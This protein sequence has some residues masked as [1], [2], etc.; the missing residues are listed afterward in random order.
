MFATQ[1]FYLNFLKNSIEIYEYRISFIHGK[2]VVI[3]DNW[4][5]VGSPNIDHFSLLLAHEANVVVQESAFATQLKTEIML[6]IHDSAHRIMLKE[7]PHE[8]AKN[9]F[10]LDWIMDCL[11]CFWV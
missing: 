10:F 6:S 1:N 11:G 9:T 2:V 8:G 3:D 7:W 4:A 5:T